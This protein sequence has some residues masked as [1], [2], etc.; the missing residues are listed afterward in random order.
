MLKHLHSVIVSLLDYIM[1]SIRAEA[2]VCLSSCVS[3]RAI[4]PG[5]QEKHYQMNKVVSA[6]GK[7]ARLLGG[8]HRHLAFSGYI[9]INIHLPPQV[10]GQHLNGGDSYRALRFSGH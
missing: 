8:R 6:L 1:S 3:R 5:S 10:G 2:S 7:V 4:D 9:N